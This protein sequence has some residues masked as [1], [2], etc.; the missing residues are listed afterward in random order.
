LN[1]NSN[2]TVVHFSG[3]FNYSRVNNFGASFAT[4]DLLLFLNNDTEVIDSNWLDELC[5]WATREQVGAVGGKLLTRG[6]RIQHAGV[7]VGLTGYAGHIFSGLPENRWSTFG[8]AEWYRDYSAVTAACIII[9]REVFEQLGG[10][11]EDF[12]LCG[13]DVELCLRIWK[14]GL[15]VIYNPFARLKHFEGST[16]VGEIPAQD[17]VVSYN[18]Y[19]PLLKTGDPFFNP[20]LSYWNTIPTPAGQGDQSPLEFVNDYLKSLGE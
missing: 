13:S 20:N 9:K 3:D 11:D 17:F 18:F 12:I 5:M 6:G 19:L 8:L 16:R 7:V 2:I 14:N 10:F 15:R 1:N 4:G